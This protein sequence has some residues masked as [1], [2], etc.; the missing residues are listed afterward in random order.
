MKHFLVWV[1]IVLPF[2]VCSEGCTLLAQKKPCMVPCTVPPIYLT[3]GLPCVVRCVVPCVVHCTVCRTLCRI[4][5]RNTR[6]TMCRIFK[7]T[8]CVKVW[9][10]LV[11]A[12]C[13]LH[14]KTMHG[15]MY[16]PTYLPDVCPTD[17]GTGDSVW[18]SWDGVWHSGDSA[19]PLG[20]SIQHSGGNAGRSGNS[21]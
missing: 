18:R 13:L 19:W 21:V 11:N 3:G 7:C 17:S 14:K 1:L 5:C 15:A 8:F 20:N 6:R 12:L 9:S 2:P 4:L 10:L 16:C